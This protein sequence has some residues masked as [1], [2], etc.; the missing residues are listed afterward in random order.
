NNIWKINRETPSIDQ[1]NFEPSQEVSSAN[2]KAARKRLQAWEATGCG[3]PTPRQRN[4]FRAIYV[5][6][7]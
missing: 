3:C 4:L 7:M 6:R 2:F 1:G 5:R